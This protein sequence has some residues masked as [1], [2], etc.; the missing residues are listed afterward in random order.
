MKIFHCLKYLFIFTLLFS[1][2]CGSS[3]NTKVDLENVQTITVA[4]QPSAITLY[5]SGTVGPLKV[6]TV[7]SPV[8][9]TVSQK[10]F[11]YGT[12][13]DKDQLLLVLK[14]SQLAEEYQTS[15]TTY[16][17]AKK[18]YLNNLTQL[19]GTDYL[20]KLGI[21]SEN[22]YITTQS[23]NFDLELGY[24]QAARKL[25]QTLEKMGN[26]VGNI[27]ELHIEQVE[28][29]HKALA[30]PADTLKITAP[31]SGI[32]LMPG[33]GSGGS[34]SS[35]SSGGLLTVG[36]Q[37][38]S[39]QVLLGIG[40]SSGV[41]LL[42]KINEVNINNIKVGQP[43]IIT[44]DAFPNITLNGIVEHIVQQAVPSESGGTPTFP[45]NIIVAH[46]TDEQK[47]I[48]HM[49][50]SAKVALQIQSRPAIRVPISAIIVDQGIPTVKVLDPKYDKIVTVPVV[51][52]STTL[53]TVEIQQGL[54]PGDKVVINA[55]DKTS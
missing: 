26:S 24:N 11:E 16:L 49:G 54:K 22:E 17:K 36:S 47:K 41:S 37:I 46:L 31:I 18:D 50:M 15:L 52:G 27:M 39:G 51:T 14:S 53:D 40:D 19:R 28:A 29:V 43:A 12:E 42:V 4:L 33:K 13:V 35:D 5:F 2:G 8:D 38:K 23:T 7:N 25:Q 9:G 6:M 1:S 34:D 48:I 45:V 32:T 21:I 55:A 44:S 30:Q 20:K 3:N 10:L